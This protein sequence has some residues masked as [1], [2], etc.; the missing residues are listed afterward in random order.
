MPDSGLTGATTLLL[1]LLVVFN[2][3]YIRHVL[4][5]TYVN[6]DNNAVFWFI[7]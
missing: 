5:S 7:L 1:P 6:D 2:S 4:L 3:V